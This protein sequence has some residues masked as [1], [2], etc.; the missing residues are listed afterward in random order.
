MHESTNEVYEFETSSASIKNRESSRIRSE[1]K[2]GSIRTEIARELHA[3]RGARTRVIAVARER[4]TKIGVS[5]S[6]SSE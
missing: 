2:T 1:V 6:V 3:E 4:A 5:F